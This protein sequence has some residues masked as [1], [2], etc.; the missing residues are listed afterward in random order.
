MEVVVF[1]HR[2]LFFNKRLLKEGR[3]FFF[4]KS[5]VL[6]K[7]FTYQEKTAILPSCLPCKMA[8]EL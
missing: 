2:E 7:G 4:L 3:F 8:A 5:S 6:E 1:P